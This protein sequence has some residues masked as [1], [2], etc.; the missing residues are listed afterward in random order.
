MKSRKLVSS[1]IT[2][3]VVTSIASPVMTQA[4]TVQFKD[5]SPQS[6]YYNDV[7]WLVQQGIINGYPDETYR[8]NDALS[9]EQAA[10]MFVRALQLDIPTNAGSILEKYID[11]DGKSWSAG[12]LSAFINA[13]ITEDTT[14]FR[15]KDPLTRE[16]MASWLVAAFDFT[17]KNAGSVPFKDLEDISFE[18]LDDIRIL[19]Q[20]NIVNG[21]TDGTYDPKSAV[22]RAQFASFMK[23]AITTQSIVEQQNTPLK[24]DDV[25]SINLKQIKITTNH[26]GYNNQQIRNKS[27]YKL[28]DEN[29]NI[30][31]TVDVQVQ[32]TEITLTL[33]KQVK[34]RAYVI[35]DPAITG[36]EENISLTFS[37]DEKPKVESIIPTS[38][39][40]YL[41][42]FSEPLN[43]GV[44]NDQQ[45]IDEELFDSIEIDGYKYRV[46]KMTVQQ[47]GKAL[48]VE[49]ET[50]LRE[51]DHELEIVDTDW[52]EDYA[53]NELEATAYD[54]NMKYEKAAPQLL[55]VKNVQPNQLTL[56]FDKQI[57]LRYR[58]YLYH[59]SSSYYPEKATVQNGNELV[60]T[61]DS[62]DL[63]TK[64]TD[65]VVDNGAIEDLWG[66]QNTKMTKAIKIADD[67]TPP[68]ITNVEFVD[69]T[70]ANSSY[71]KMKVTFSESVKQDIADDIDNYEL[72]DEQGNTIK[73]RDISFDNSSTNDKVA[74]FTIDK[75]YG[76][77]PKQTYTIEADQIKDLI[78]NESDELEYRFIASSEKPPGD[79]S[80]KMILNDREDEVRIVLD[81]GKSMSV[82]GNYSITQL[83][84]YQLKINNQTLLL[85]DLKDVSGFNL[86]FTTFQDAEK[87]E[88]LIEKRG[89]LAEAWEDFFEDLV[90]A[91]KYEDIEDVELVVGRVA[92][93]NG[94]KTQS[95]F[96]N[97]KLSIQGEFD[98]N[99]VTAKASDVDTIEL[100]FEDELV[101]FDAD[102]FLVFWD[103][104]SDGKYDSNEDL[105]YE[106]SLE[107]D[108]GTS[109]IKVKLDNDELDTDAR[110]GRD[111]VYVS[112]T[113]NIQTKNRYGQMIELNNVRVQDGISPKIETYRG[114]EQVYVQPVRNDSSRAIVSLEFTDD[115]DRD[116]LTRLSFEIGNGKKYDIESAFVE[117]DDKISLVVKLNG[118]PVSNLVGE[119]VKQKAAITDENDNIISGLE[120]RINEERS[121]RT[122]P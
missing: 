49:L 102:D 86:S 57:K 87:A 94:N 48:H 38:Q 56:V 25:K 104:D 113:G 77:V 80:G 13:G 64:S 92:D 3:A 103:R 100:I 61:F 10:S 89:E 39:N 122:T 109:V 72:S 41:L 31:N 118:N 70:I 20:N 37:D 47:Y 18:Y 84:Q 69:S 43:F 79:F 67:K 105:D 96:N 15:P 30:I 26:T 76:D 106:I 17:E 42:T 46:D 32:D 54:F 59:T 88:I 73:I 101:D 34:N 117:N 7:Q 110:Y 22:T 50:R 2:A 45:L 114:T 9:R 12:A 107:K 52:F 36:Q 82:S 21:N 27:N 44:E 1:A 40:S 111:Y 55:E 5:V 91:V 119:Y 14:T 78:G 23:R 83:E 60:L 16:V 28:K 108:N 11:I 29:G 121:S 115:I 62:D 24:L 99:Q 33:E 58:G 75:Y 51:G 112:T 35:I 90:D 97:V 65:I 66:N 63:I 6:Y 53:G 98:P 120:V 116:T 19:Y 71:I 85:E 95:I 4:E 81:Y 68:S 8:P 74:T 93:E